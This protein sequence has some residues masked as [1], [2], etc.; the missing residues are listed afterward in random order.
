MTGV[1][2]ERTELPPELRAVVER[3]RAAAS[4]PVA[5]GFGVGTPE[6]AAPGGGDRRRRDHRQPPGA[7]GRRGPTLERGPAEG[8]GA[9]CEAAAALACPVVHGL[10]YAAPRVWSL[11]LATTLGCCALIVIWAIGLNPDVGGLIALGFVGIGILG[12]MSRPQ[13][14][15]RAAENI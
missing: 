3:V 4:V 1:T 15:A 9:S 12:Q 2:G 13:S 6:Q 7:R 5:V 11:F 8:V 14:L 10:I